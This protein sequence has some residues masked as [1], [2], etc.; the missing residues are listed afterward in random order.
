MF[1]GESYLPDV[2]RERPLSDAALLALL[3][4]LAPSVTFTAVPPGSG[5]RIGIDRDG[6]GFP[7][8]DELLAGTDPANAGS[9]P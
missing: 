5:V 1:S 4:G 2:S 9:K 3:H 6:D 8:G 7:D